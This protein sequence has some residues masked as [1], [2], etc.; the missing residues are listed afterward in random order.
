MSSDLH[1]PAVEPAGEDRLVGRLISSLIRSQQ[2]FRN[3]R[4]QDLSCELCMVAHAFNTVLRSLRQV[5][6]YEYEANLVYTGS[7][8]L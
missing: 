8:Q 4:S 5:D 3:D 7:T 6:V 2:L 1:V